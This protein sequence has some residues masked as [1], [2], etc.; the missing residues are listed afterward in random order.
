MCSRGRYHAEEVANLLETEG[1]DELALE[2]VV[3]I[4]GQSGW[5]SGK[6]ENRV[7]KMIPKGKG[8]DRFDWHFVGELSELVK[9]DD[10]DAGKI[11]SRKPG[12]DALAQLLFTSG[13]S[14][15]PKGVLH[16]MSTLNC[17]A[18][19][20]VN[21]LGLNREDCIFIPSPLAHQTGFL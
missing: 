7:S 21:H 11:A 9:Q 13:T 19:M 14:G 4:G 1:L 10:V 20:Q 2:N 6:E 8:T 12:P 17:A 18:A 3:V 16:R 5:R 15:E